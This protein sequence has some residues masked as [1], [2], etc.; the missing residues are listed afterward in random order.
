MKASTNYAHSP[1]ALIAI[2]I[3]LLITASLLFTPQ[4]SADF[5]PGAGNLQQVPGEAKSTPDAENLSSPENKD[6]DTTP[7]TTSTRQTNPN[8]SDKSTNVDV[9]TKPHT[10]YTTAVAVIAGVTIGMLIA[11]RYSVKRLKK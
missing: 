3:T 11:L 5:V 10:D 2:Y 1:V 9:D 6:T 7:Q 8:T 4:V